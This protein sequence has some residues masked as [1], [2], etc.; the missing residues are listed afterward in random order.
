MSAKPTPSNT[1]QHEAKRRPNTKLKKKKI[2]NSADQHRMAYY[3]PLLKTEHKVL[4]TIVPHLITV[5]LCVVSVTYGQPPIKN[6]K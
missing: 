4:D 5:S 3:Q 6:T 2:C 1:E